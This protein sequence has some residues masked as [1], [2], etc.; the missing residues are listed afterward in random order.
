[1][2]GNTGTVSVVS[3]SSPNNQPRKLQHLRL[4]LSKFFLSLTVKLH[5]F[6]LGKEKERERM[7]MK[8][9]ILRACDSGRVCV[10]V[11]VCVCAVAP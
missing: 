6:P 2:L 9:K 4:T 11:C 8:K 1:M 3:V 10:S 5:E 7:K